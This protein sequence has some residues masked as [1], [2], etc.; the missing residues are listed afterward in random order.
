MDLT[1]F[2]ATRKI[3]VSSHFIL[4]SSLI[5]FYY[6]F[7]ICAFLDFTV[8][9]TSL[10]HWKNP[11]DDIYRNVDLIMVTTA[12][13]SHYPYIKHLSSYFF[14]FAGILLYFIA[15]YYGRVKKDIN[16]STTLHVF[17][18]LLCNIAGI[19]IYIN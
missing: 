4:I 17:Y 12:L 15:L 1:Y 3:Y 14:F 7:Y 11:K 19:S 9:G 16:I 13:L 10:M 8:L 18:H 5:A 6:K 2:K